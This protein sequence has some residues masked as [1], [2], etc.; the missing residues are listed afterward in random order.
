MSKWSTRKGRAR[1]GALALTLA[2]GSG[3]GGGMEAPPMPPPEVPSPG[4]EVELTGDFVAI[5]RELSPAQRDH[6][7]QKLDGVVADAGKS[8]YLAIRRSE[9][10]K[11][12]FLT[13]FAKQYHPGG[14]GNRAGEVLGS[15]VVS[16]EEQNGRLF[17]FDVEKRKAMSDVFDPQ[18]LVEAYPIVTG[19]RPFDRLPGA[20]QYVLIDPTEGLNRYGVVGDRVGQEGVHFQVELSFA[21]RFRRLADGVAYEQVFTGYA[22]LPW[23]W[24]SHYGED[25]A[26]RT[27]GTLAIS[28]RRYKEGPGYTPTPLPPREHYFRS[29]RRLVPN[30]TAEQ[31]EQVALKWNIHPGMKPIRWHIM[32]TVLE[33]QQDPRF[34]GY[35]VVGAVKRG[36][37]GWNAAFG[38]P[39]LE[40]VVGGGMQDFGDDDRNV[41]IFDT[42]E[43]MPMAFANWRSNP[44]TGELRGAS[45][46]Y[47]VS[48]WLFAL[49]AFAEGAPLTEAAADVVTAPPAPRLGLSWSGMAGTGP[50]ELSASD[51]RQVRARLQASADPR[52]AALT[53]KQKVEAHIT[54]VML[55]EVGHT[56]G[57]RHNFSG[58]RSNDGSPDSP[59]STSVMDYLLDEDRVLMDAPGEYDVRAV[60]YLYGLSPEVP[61]TDAFCTDDDRRVDPYC[62]TYD[63]FA[64]SLPLHHGPVFQGHL[65]YFLTST[66]S[67]PR[68]QFYFDYVTSPYLGFLR[69]PDPATQAT[70]YELAMQKLRPPLVVP[71]DARPDYA[72][73][74]DELTR[75]L[76]QRLYLDPAS[77][78][79]FFTND[80]PSSPALLTPM[81]ADIEAIILNTDGVRSHAARRTLVDVLKAQQSLGAYLLLRELR[82]TLT[83]SLPSLP[84]EERVLIED[85][86]TR[87]SGALSPYYH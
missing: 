40:A 68:L 66:N 14:V 9:L 76:F 41:V 25:N 7:A 28:L 2:F 45:I 19:H 16:F 3:C 22:D 87:I 42:D 50:C 59:V 73:R 60:R 36:I 86:V 26:F 18:I 5:P 65:D 81:L 30:T 83:D 56:L 4:L 17:V 29:D 12:W 55:H 31:F 1:W 8:F 58:S 48:W 38:F 32:D 74:A 70:A 78:R 75:R 15:R 33:A 35:D 61:A 39:V 79:G 63:R 77:S 27:A 46:Y 13:A 85:L 23:E 34:Q 21:Q 53:Q 11:R 37:E 44:I 24:A 10:R 82:G 72:V 49:E 6:V 64:D 84:L 62:A 69:I 51:P 47:S 54:H 20:S 71:P 43:L 57:L 52:L 80:P 67:W